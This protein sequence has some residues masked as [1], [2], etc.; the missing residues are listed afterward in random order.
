MTTALTSLALPFVWVTPTASQWWIFAASGL[1]GFVAHF[2]MARALALADASALAPLHYVRLVWAIGIG[3]VV[4]GDVPDAWT[5]AGGALI[6]GAG[7]YVVEFRKAG[8]PDGAPESG[9]Q[10]PNE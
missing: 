9:D 6:I 10:R 5:L 3:F 7:L 4:F 8:D 2:S 1:L